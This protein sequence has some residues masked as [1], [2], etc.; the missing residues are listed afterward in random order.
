HK[1]KIQLNGHGYKGKN[2]R[3]IQLKNHEEI[4]IQSG[5]PYARTIKKISW[6]S[7]G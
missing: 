1:L 3:D 2:P 6:G 7:V 5:P 4:V